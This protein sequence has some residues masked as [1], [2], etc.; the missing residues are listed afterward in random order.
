MERLIHPQYDLRVAQKLDFWS[1]RRYWSVL[2]YIRYKRAEIKRR[3]A[4]NFDRFIGI[5]R[6]Y[7][8]KTNGIDP[9]R[10]ALAMEEYA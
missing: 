3:R 6:K 1:D 4:R 10:A 8:I 2:R 7:A 5:R 9:H